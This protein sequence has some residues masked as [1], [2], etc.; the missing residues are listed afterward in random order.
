MW[1]KTI[2]PYSVARKVE[3]IN[4]RLSFSLSFMSE[5]NCGDAAEVLVDFT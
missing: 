2:H 4:Q 5:K 1:P 3:I